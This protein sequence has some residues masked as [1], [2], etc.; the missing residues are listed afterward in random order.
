MFPQDTLRTIE[1]RGFKAF[2]TRGVTVEGHS[3]CDSDTGPVAPAFLGAAQ[4][5]MLHTD[6]YTEQL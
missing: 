1:H 6:C 4:M 2:T 3:G 5:P